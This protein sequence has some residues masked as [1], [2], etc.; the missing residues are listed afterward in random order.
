M[1]WA[2]AAGDASPSLRDLPTL[3]K[4][5]G[6]ALGEPLDSHIL[7]LE[8]ARHQVMVVCFILAERWNVPCARC[9]DLR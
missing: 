8:G 1:E 7:Y 3:Q 9:S 6:H 2:R 4:V 5:C